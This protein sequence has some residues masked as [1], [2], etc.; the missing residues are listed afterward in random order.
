VAEPDHLRRI[1]SMTHYA[2]SLTI[3]HR[4]AIVI[5]QNDS[6]ELTAEGRFAYLVSFNRAVERHWVTAIKEAKKDGQL[7]SDI[8]PRLFYRFIRDAILG[9]IAWFRPV[10]G[11]DIED[12]AD[13]LLDI[14]L[15]GAAVPRTE[16]APLATPAQEAMP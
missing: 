9:S 4:A 3:D 8:E 7:R 14:V 5:I 2:Y 15:G 10:P 6:E 12:L 11:L 13:A 1:R 16:R